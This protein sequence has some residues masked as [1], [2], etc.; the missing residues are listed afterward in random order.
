MQ[1]AKA[2]YCHF[3]V[4]GYFDI[5]FRDT[6]LLGRYISSY[7]KVAPRRKSG[8]CA[9]HQRKLATAIKRARFMALMPYLIQ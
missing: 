1:F 8:T 4:N 9:W 6:Q 5:D 7:G 2:K 3:C